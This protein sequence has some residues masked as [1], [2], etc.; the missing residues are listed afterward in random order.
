MRRC[1]PGIDTPISGLGRQSSPWSTNSG[2]WRSLTSLVRWLAWTHNTV[3]R[4]SVLPAE[5]D[6]TYP[7]AFGLAVSLSIIG[8]GQTGATELAAALSV[9]QASSGVPHLAL[10]GAHFTYP[11]VNGAAVLLWIFAFLGGAVL[12][13]VFKGTWRQR[14]A[15]RAFT[16]HVGPIEPL[17]RVPEVNVINDSRP[18]AFCAGY[19]RPAVYVSRRTVDLLT[20]D[21]L[22]AVL[23]HEQ[24]HRRLRDPLRIAAGRITGEALFFI[25]VLKALVAREVDVAELRADRAAV[26]A[27]GGGEAALASALLAFDE[28]GPVGSTGISP[29]RVD[30]L[31]GQPSR[32]RLPVNRVA[33]SVVILAAGTL[34]VWRVTGI[35]SVH[36]SFNLPGFSSRPCIAIMTVVPVAAAIRILVRW[37][38]STALSGSTVKREI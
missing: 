19:L 36:A 24:H 22:D 20:D 4:L 27:S 15:Y 35:A 10:A 18:Q 9:H 1:T 16:A 13:A 33:A 6:I 34:I 29:E 14:R 5:N 11:S 2:M 31:L 25:P 17:R 30:A 7:G 26:G 38:R 3:D 28:S 32:W 21:E 8:L 37:A 23:A 12:N